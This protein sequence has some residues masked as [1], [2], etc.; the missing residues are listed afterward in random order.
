M[1][2]SIDLEDD[3]WRSAKILAMDEKKSLQDVVNDALRE[4]LKKAK[5]HT[6]AKGGKGE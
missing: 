2:T 5:K 1:K 3:L 6:D 4:Y